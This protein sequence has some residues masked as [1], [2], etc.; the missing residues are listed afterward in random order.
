MPHMYL[1]V[2]TPSVPHS[3][4]Q[5]QSLYVR[6]YPDQRS[7][8]R[9]PCFVP[10]TLCCLPSSGCWRSTPSMPLSAPSLAPLNLWSFSFTRENE[11]CSWLLFE[12]VIAA[13]VER[14]TSSPG[15]SGANI[16]RIDTFPRK[17]LL[18][19]AILKLMDTS[20]DGGLGQCL[21][22]NQKDPLF[23]EFTG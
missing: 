21:S 13:F 17:T 7:P 4:R 5:Y 19:S 9:T 8:R 16:G 20:L 2:Y 11:T 6:W 10:S 15:V 14:S 18:S 23:S 1:K 22:L 12:S 3:T